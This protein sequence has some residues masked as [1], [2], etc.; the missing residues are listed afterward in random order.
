MM[1]RTAQVPIAER[2]PA[3][4]RFLRT[5]DTNQSSSADNRRFSKENSEWGRLEGNPTGYRTKLKRLSRHWYAR[6]N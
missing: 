2:H 1:T 5:P 3:S 4:A 6:E